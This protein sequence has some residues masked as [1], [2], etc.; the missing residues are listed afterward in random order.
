VT[1]LTDIE[2]QAWIGLLAT[3][4]GLDRALD[5][6][7]QADAGISHATYAVL[8][9][10]SNSESGVRHMSDLAGLANYSQSRLSHAVA[11]LED[12]GLIRRETCPSDR[13]AV[14]AAL[15]D[16]GREL[17]ER[18]AP[19]HVAAVRAMVFDRL[20]PEQ[21]AA[22]A[23]ITTVIYAGLVHDGGVPLLP[24]PESSR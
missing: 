19:G 6:Q 14:H 16:Q 5:R 24:S 22:L 2:R 1:W 9:A 18:A 10:L 15:T 4:S 11:R 20:S 7:L 3:Y 23:E 8:A 17:I 13:R 21:T 12:D